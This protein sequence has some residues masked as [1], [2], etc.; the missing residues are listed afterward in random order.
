MPYN[1]DSDTCL[2]YLSCFHSF[3]TAGHKPKDYNKH[4]VRNSWWSAIDRLQCFKSCSWD[5]NLPSNPCLLCCY[6]LFVCALLL[7]KM[8]GLQAVQYNKGND[9][10]QLA[11]K[12][13]KEHRIC[14]VHSRPISSPSLPL[15]ETSFP[16]RSIDSFLLIHHE[17]PGAYKRQG[18]AAPDTD[19]SRMYEICMCKKSRLEAQPSLTSSC[20]LNFLASDHI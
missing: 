4:H 3:L 15:V 1:V 5:C 18:I 6:E 11:I 12:L 7:N 20:W 10:L 19:V 2:L 17:R 16:A 13:Y 8:W 9:D 14:A